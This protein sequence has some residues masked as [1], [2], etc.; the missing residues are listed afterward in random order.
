MLMR[1]FQ[2]ALPLL[3]GLGLF[4]QTGIPA[5]TVLPAELQ[6]SLNSAK[7]RPGQSIT[8]RIMQDVPLPNGK[9]IRAGSKIVGHVMDAKSASAGQHAGITIQFERVNFA[10]QSVPIF[11]S[12]RAVASVMEV[13]YAQVPI[14][15][16]DRGTPY[17]WASR[18]LIGGQVAYGEGGPVASGMQ[19]VGRFVPGGGVLAPVEGN[20]VLRSPGIFSFLSNSSFSPQNS[21]CS[22]DV[23]GN[24]APQALWV[25]STDACGVY[26]ISN[27]AIARTGRGEPFGQIALVAKHGEVNVER[28]SGMLIRVMS[29]RPQ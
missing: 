5:G 1:L 21:P 3:F 7:I 14:T 13:E 9:K 24:Q 22:A 29:G 17:A 11:A 19:E 16:P 10:H 20:P 8:A 27:I 26:G 4:A 25:F 2:I 18:E 28:G 12:L 23:I 6:T 15:G